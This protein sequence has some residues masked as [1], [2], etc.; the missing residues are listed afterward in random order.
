MK[1]LRIE[2]IMILPK[3][4]QNVSDFIYNKNIKPLFNLDCRCEDASR[5]MF[6]SISKASGIVLQGL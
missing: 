1:K 6:S 5:I 2:D 4:K 3:K